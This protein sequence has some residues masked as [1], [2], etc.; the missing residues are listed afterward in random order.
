MG[1]KDREPV[2]GMAGGE[3]KIL[4]DAKVE[5]RFLDGTYKPYPIIPFFRAVL[6]EKGI[7]DGEVSMAVIEEKIIVY[8][9]ELYLIFP[10]ETILTKF[11]PITKSAGLSNIP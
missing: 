7:P 5:F 2:M 4:D 6:S 10:R 3:F 9:G 1:S 8:L 11:A